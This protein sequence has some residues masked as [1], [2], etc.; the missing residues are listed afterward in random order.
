MTIMTKHIGRHK[1]TGQRL[2]VVFMRLPEEPEN[3]LVVYSDQLID[4]YHDDFMT[5]VESPEC[6]SANSLYEGLQRKV[7]WHGNPMLDTLHKEGFLKKVPTSAVVMQPTPQQQVALDDIL[8]QMDKIESENPTP[9]VNDNTDTNAGERVQEQ[10]DQSLGEDNKAIAQNLLMQAV[11]LEKEAEKKREEAVKYDPSLTEKAMQ[12]A[13]RGRG[14]PKG[15]TK[16]AI[17]AKSE[18][19][20]TSEAVSSEA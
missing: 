5:A 16:E 2:T 15:T 14:R 6:Q 11:L 8:G 3:A 19:T 18:T 4:K 17:A 13:K 1:G 10:V 20:T 12:P 7:F 9:Q